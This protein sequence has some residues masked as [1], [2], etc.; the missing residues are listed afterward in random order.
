MKDLHKFNRDMLQEE[1][2]FDR[3]IMFFDYDVAK[4]TVATIFPWATMELELSNVI[5]LLTAI[6]AMIYV[7]RKAFSKPP[8]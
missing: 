6:F 2:M 5:K 7:A 4:V 1:T 3:F 8:K